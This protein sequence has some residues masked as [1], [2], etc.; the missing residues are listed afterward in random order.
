M[1]ELRLFGKPYTGVNPFGGGNASYVSRILA[2]NPLAFYDANISPLWQDSIR[3]TPAIAEA[4]VIGAWDDLSGNGHHI[5]QAVTANKPTLRLGVQNNRP[6]IRFDGTDDYLQNAAF[7][8]FGDNYTAFFIASFSSDGSADASQGVF[9]VSNGSTTTGFITYHSS[10]LFW[11]ARDA[12]ATR[13]ASNGNTRDGV[14][15]LWN[16]HNSST[17][18]ELWLNGVSQDTSIY[19]SPNPNTLDQLDVGR[20]LQAGW[21]LW[22]DLP[23]LIIFNRTL[24]DIERDDVA[25]IFN[26]EYGVF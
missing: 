13:A 7:P 9:E 17:E 4:D 12:A 16:M 24:S 21:F 22:G 20:N 11:V 18:L 10:T 26:T 23:A 5:I 8:D 15:R 14:V 1:R 19:T 6:I 2:H 25:A 3:T